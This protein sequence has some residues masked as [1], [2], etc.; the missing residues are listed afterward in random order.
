MAKAW[1]MERRFPTK[2]AREKADAAI[3]ALSSTEPMHVYIDTWLAVYRENG[4]LEKR[5]ER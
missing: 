5:S 3:D 4:G 2:Q 1:S